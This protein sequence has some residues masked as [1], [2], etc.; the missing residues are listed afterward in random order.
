M[1]APE[2]EAFL[3]PWPTSGVSPLPEV[4]PGEGR[5]S[6]RKGTP[7]LDHVDDN[8]R[9]IYNE[10]SDCRLGASH[11]RHR[12]AERVRPV[13]RYGRRGDTGTVAGVEPGAGREAVAA[14]FRFTECDAHA[15]QR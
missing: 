1:G 15:G 2:V 3:T 13:P 12:R 10:S 14:T 6:R 9:G 11:S 4:D 5:P 8:P 7:R